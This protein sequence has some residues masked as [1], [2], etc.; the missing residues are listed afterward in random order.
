MKRAQRQAR[1][2]GKISGTGQRP[3]LSVFRSGKHIFAQLINDEKGETLISGSDYDLKKGTKVER[4][5][6][7]GEKLAASALKKKI[8]KAVFDRGGFRYHGRIKALA[9]GARKGGLEF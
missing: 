4:A 5:G 1:I 3:R 7:V 8:K 9:E 6:E 2:R